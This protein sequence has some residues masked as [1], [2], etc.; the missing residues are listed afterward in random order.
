LQIEWNPWQESYSP[1]N[2]VLSALCPQLNLLN[3]SP[4]ISNKIPV[5]ATSR[6]WKP[7]LRTL[8]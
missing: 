7:D 2:S 8:A 6:Y 1:Q 5:Y 3:N 4:P